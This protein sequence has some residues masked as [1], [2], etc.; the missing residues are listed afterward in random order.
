MKL[1][2]RRIVG[3]PCWIVRSS[4]LEL[5]KSSC[6]FQQRGNSNRS[7]FASRTC[8]AFGWTEASTASGLPPCRTSSR[9]KLYETSL[10]REIAPLALPRALLFFTCFADTSTNGCR[11]TTPRQS[12]ICIIVDVSRYRDI[13]AC[14]YNLAIHA[15]DWCIQFNDITRLLIAESYDSDDNL[16]KYYGNGTRDG[17]P[18]FNFKFI[19]HIRDASD[20]DSI[21]HILEKWLK[22][23]PKNSGTNWV[24]IKS[25]AWLISSDKEF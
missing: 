5:R 17:I 9:M 14:I 23:L 10:S 1:D 6:S 11:E 18:P 12:G 3:D 21:I 13:R 15:L 2:Y 4:E 16:I 22:L 7:P 8:W 24:V 25:C 20:A 19:T